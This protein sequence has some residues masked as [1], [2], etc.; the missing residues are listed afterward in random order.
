MGAPKVFALSICV[1]PFRRAKYLYDSFKNTECERSIGPWRDDA[2]DV[3]MNR[4]DD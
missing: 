4:A 1:E 3:K 2:N